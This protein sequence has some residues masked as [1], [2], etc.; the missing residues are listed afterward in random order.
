MFERSPWFYILFISLGNV[1]AFPAGSHKSQSVCGYESC[2]KG[3]PGMLNVHLIAHTHDDVGWLKTVDQYYF[4]SHTDTQNAG[5]QYILDSVIQALLHDPNK[6]FIY[7]ET[8]FFWKWWMRQHDSVRHQVKILVNSGQLEFV[9][10]GWSMNDEA[11][12]NYMSTID[13]MTWGFRKLN[14][15]FGECGRPKVGWQI[16]PF[17]HSRDMA[18]T[19]ALMGMDGLFFARLDYMDKENRLK[20]K[21][22]EM[23]WKGSPNIGKKSWLFTG[24]L[25]NH[26]Q[27]PP[28]FCFDL[29]CDDEPIIDDKH[30]PEY[31]VDDKVSRFISFIGNESKYY[32]TDNVAVTMGG[33]FNYQDANSWFTNLDKIISYVNEKQ[34]TEGSKV[35]VFY[36]TPSCYLKSLNGANITWPEKSD[37]FFPYASD[38]HTYWTGYYTSRPAIKYFERLGNNFLQ[39]C[40]QLYVLGEIGPEDQVDLNSMREAM[41]VMQH[42]D[43]ITGTEKQVVAS[44]YARI[45]S[46][47]FEECSAVTSAAIQKLM[48]PATKN[49]KNDLLKDVNVDEV[50]DSSEEIGI[51]AAQAPPTVSISSCLLLNISQCEVSEGSDP[52]TVIVYNP[53][54]KIVNHTVRVP[55]SGAS[56]IVKDPNGAELTVQVVPIPQEVLQIPGR[57]SSAVNELVFQAE[58]L[59]PAGF[60]SYYIS[61]GNNLNTVIEQFEIIGNQKQLKQGRGNIIKIGSGDFKVGIGAKSGLIELIERGD[62]KAEIKQEILYYES[63]AGDNSI[64]AKRASGAY[65]FRPN[66][67]DAVPMKSKINRVTS[68]VYRGELVDEVHQQFSSWASQVVRVHK[69]KNYAELNWVVGPIPIEDGIGKEIIMRFTSNIQNNGVFYTDSNGREMLQRMRRASSVENNPNKELEDS[70]LES[71]SGNYYPVTSRIRIAGLMGETP[72]VLSILT[73]RAQGGSSVKDGEV[74]LMI[75]R[76]LLHDD[77]FG[78]GE[79]L[80]ETAYG[81]G[82]VVR[83]Q[84][85]VILGPMAADAPA[86]PVYAEERQMAEEKLLAP[87]LFFSKT[88]QSYEEWMKNTGKEF[89]GLKPTL[90]PNVHVLTLEPWSGNTVLLRLEHF[91]EMNEDAILSKPVTL[92]LEKL[93]A[94]IQPTFIRET[95]LGANQWL[96]N[97]K[98][99]NWKSESNSVTEDTSGEENF[100]E[101]NEN[102]VFDPT[103]VTLGPMDIRTFVIGLPKY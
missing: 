65:I 13:Q 64:F 55:V 26:Y 18:S 30:S 56:Y 38:P 91:Y 50:S 21:S 84:N 29:L 1:I 47:G 44:D 62:L 85:I 102:G 20:S 82:L 17:G 58:L 63:M 101:Q 89:V 54:S 88:Q 5:V 90:P 77:A 35:N 81:T 34:E 14:D 48:N 73:D 37:D 99:M 46:K 60:K 15:T 68:K 41:G 24:V 10:G 19:F 45:L 3:V 53:L 74:E 66:G 12:T 83:G 36:S 87:W 33:D 39:V 100:L 70:V 92:N 23:V 71:I 78:V 7:V 96:E 43:A 22:A 97:S 11:V 28:G 57:V 59:P 42:H 94:F 76:R 49:R 32:A 95:T 31:N 80:N 16:D 61:Q 27:P 103:Q 9:G 67:T 8:A 86:S 69:D 2:P 98:R 51:G 75:H 93:L 4:G 72:A 40:K 52:F 25:Y 79:A 6:K